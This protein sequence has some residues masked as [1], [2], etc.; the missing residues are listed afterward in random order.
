MKNELWK[1]VKCVFT[2]PLHH[3]FFWVTQSP[4]L[5]HGSWVISSKQLLFYRPH[6]FWIMS[7][8]NRIISLKTHCIQTCSKCA[9]LL[10]PLLMW[11]AFHKLNC[12]RV[13]SMPSVTFL[14]ELGVGPSPL[15]AFIIISESLSTMI[16]LS[17][18]SQA[19]CITNFITIY[20][21]W[22]DN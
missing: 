6:Q 15:N 7:D 4:K 16:S 1:Q 5:S 3:S 14:I 18:R 17:P 21:N 19:N 12:L 22:Y 10:L 9:A 2:F 13:I 8:E 11:E 20:I